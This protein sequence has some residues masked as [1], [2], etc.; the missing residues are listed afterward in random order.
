MR[1][2][3]RPRVRV[4]DG[5]GTEAQGATLMNRADPAPFGSSGP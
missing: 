4:S 5:R 1:R 2:W 3:L